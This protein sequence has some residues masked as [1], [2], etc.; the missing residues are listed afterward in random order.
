MPCSPQLSRRPG[1]LRAN[2]FGASLLAAAL[3]GGCALA[4]G[5]VSGLFD[6]GERP[7]QRSLVAG[8]RA[9]DDARYPLAEQALKEVLSAGLASARDR[10][11][12]HKH[13]AFIY[14]TSA[15]TVAC[16]GEFRAARNADAAFA[17]SKAE[18]GHPQW[19]LVWQR[20]RQ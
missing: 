8:L 2:P 5:R 4:P 3:L 7:A 16:E 10:A 11:A 13:L 15:R 12:A 14:C 18:A 19:G 9:Y 1:F 6:G 17:L 20:V